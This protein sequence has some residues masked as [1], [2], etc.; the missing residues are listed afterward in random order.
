MHT[1]KEIRYSEAVDG[2]TAVFVGTQQI[3]S[4][5]QNSDGSFDAE[6]DVHILSCEKTTVSSMEQAKEWMQ[7]C[8]RTF[9][10]RI[11]SDPE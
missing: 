9:L 11:A 1:I 7:F 5:Q 4:I 6:M 10:I 3:G 2:L 8:W